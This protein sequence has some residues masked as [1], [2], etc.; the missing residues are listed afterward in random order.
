MNSKDRLKSLLF[1][2]SVAIASFFTTSPAPAYQMGYMAE[3]M[4]PEYMS[5]DLIVFAEGLNLDDTQEV[6]VEAM[7][8]SYEDDFQ[9]GWAATQERLNRIAEE[10]KNRP[11]ASNK[12]TLEPVLMLWVTG[13]KKREHSMKDCLKMF[14]QSLF[15]TNDYF[16]PVSTKSCIEKST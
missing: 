11:S 15:K 5:R 3:A 1:V 10:I 14:M 12:E 6:I 7:F 2:A 9:S 4:R 16:G 8:D 13:W